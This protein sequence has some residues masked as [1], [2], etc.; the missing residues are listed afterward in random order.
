MIVKLVSITE[1]LG[2]PDELGEA[3]S[4]QLK[5]TTG[6]NIVECAGRTCYDSFGTGR[7]SAAYHG[8]IKEVGHGSVT[9]HSALGFYIEGISRGCSHE[10]VR[11]RAGCAISQRSTRY[12][13][14][15]ES[16]WS[17]HPLLLEYWKQD[18][19]SYLQTKQV[20]A[21]CRKQYKSLSDDLFTWLVGRGIDKF[22]ARKQARGAARCVLGTALS[23][24]LIWTANIRALR[25]FLE[26]RANPAADAE[27]RVLAN[28]VYTLCLERLPSYFNDYTKVECTD[29]IGFGL[30]T[31][32]RKI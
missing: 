26:Q 2:L 13:D 10:L 11:H 20:E 7:D 29:G 1:F 4:D 3:R 19:V 6:E 5:G 8:H 17:Y 22:T 30:T 32:H 31:P 25:T 23:T 21:I 18:G 15:S 16:D 14:E 9:E 12:V 27:I 24:A 28:K